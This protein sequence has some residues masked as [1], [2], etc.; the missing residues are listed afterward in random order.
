MV[1]TP[2]RRVGNR[3]P[4]MSEVGATMATMA[5]NDTASPPSAPGAEGL[6]AML[7]RLG[8]DGRLVHVAE[9]PGRAGVRA[10]WPVWVS[11]QLRSAYAEAGIPAPWRHQAEAAEAARSGSHTVVATGTGS[12]KSL[13]A[14]LPTIQAVLD[15][16]TAATD[17]HARSRTS[18]AAY[19]RRP[20]ALYLAP[21]KALAAD[22]VHSLEGLLGNL[23]AP[24]RVARCDGD[25]ERPDRDFARSYADVVASNL[26][27]LHAS[28]LPG[29]ERWSRLLRGLHFVVLDEL[30]AYRGIHGAHASLVLRRLLR[31]ARHLGAEPTVIAMSAT[32]AEPR[33]TLACM[34]GVA[35]EDVAAITED[36][37]P[38][39]C[40][41]LVLWQPKIVEDADG[42]AGGRRGGS[43]HDAEIDAALAALLEPDD[44]LLADPLG[45]PLLDAAVD[46]DPLAPMPQEAIR[47]PATVEAAE[48]LT[49][50]VT[51]GARTLTFV[52]SRFAAE[53]VAVMA[54]ERLTRVAAEVGVDLA[55]RVATYRGGYLPEE[56]RELERAL[57]SG[58]LLGLATTTA[59]ELGIDIAGLDAVIMTGW[60]GT[61]V[62]MRQQSGRAGRAGQ[63]GVAVLIASENPL[64]AYL[65]HH[66]EAIVD[67]PIEA[68]TFDPANPYVLGP[69]LCAAASELP[70]RAGDLPLFG[71]PDEGF[72]AS[73]AERDLL[74]RRP[75][76][77]F[78]N[79][80]LPLRP[81][82]LTDIR[83]S[84]GS[85]VSIVDAVTGTVLG[86][87]DGSRADATVHPG[88]IYLHQGRRYFVH[89]LEE[90][91]ALVEEAPEANFRT[92]AHTASAVDILAVR[93]EGRGPVR[94]V[95]ASLGAPPAGTVGWAF[96]DVDVTSQVTE[97]ERRRVPGGDVLGVVPLDMPVHTLPTTAV[98]WT[99]DEAAIA[100][101]GI[102]RGRLPG[103]LHAME[104]AAIGMLPLLATCD[105]WDLGGLSTALHPDTGAATVVVHDAHA[106]GAGFAERGYGALRRWWE[107]T[108][109]VIE[110]CGCRAGCPSCVQSPK[111]GNGNNPLDKDG[112][113]VLL[114]LALS[115]LPA[116]PT[117]SAPGP[118]EPP[119]P[120]E[121]IMG[122]DTDRAVPGGVGTAR[123]SD[124]ED[125]AASVTEPPRGDQA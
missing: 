8:A 56:R 112:A 99:F 25:S 72:L 42:P 121:A 18:I 104:H 71:L 64:D 60:P 54:R 93:S 55:G 115:A 33:A 84:S 122:G 120:A 113:A 85:T 95:P 1:T 69:H 124:A 106:G 5:D 12:G 88:A 3:A 2:G 14:W 39:G 81:Q 108:A 114:C 36:A 82:D 66:P 73:L 37:S 16:E 116:E 119:G 77:W 110:G 92:R 27:F 87:V 52:R 13:A 28:M 51:L 97:F 80:S 58:R 43:E 23:A 96:G 83:G 67:A 62:S 47:R 91:V 94:W 90:D 74:R 30:H 79:V 107:A 10:P 20:T 49:D 123:S 75:A 19:R 68:T 4:R 24:V 40:R 15:A 45:D 111:C 100:A 86:T 59:L 117:P 41:H 9:E 21:T 17:E 11:P 102:D 76:G 57:R 6:L 105:R 46:D 78:W 118:A 38:A 32:T 70:L 35:P 34:V 125:R 26:D 7:E 44:P 48:L 61:R 31:L 22:Q 103:A 53:S 65:V 101:S 50:L 109:G 89:A 98:W 29:H 63:D